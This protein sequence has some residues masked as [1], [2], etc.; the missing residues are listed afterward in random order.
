MSD[1]LGQALDQLLS[2]VA[3]KAAADPGQSYTAKLLRG[4]P[5][6]CAKKLGEE[7]VEMALAVAG[8]SPTEIAQEAADLLYHLGVA[9]QARGVTGA[10]VA[11]VLA[12]R[13]GTSGLD[14]KAGRANL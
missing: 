10:A 4:G 11:E 14:E 13:R 9:L 12:A 2:D 5:S 8:G 7:A 1:T 3:D 6:L